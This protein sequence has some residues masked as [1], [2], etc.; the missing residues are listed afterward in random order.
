[1]RDFG[2]E[3]LH[4]FLEHAGCLANR[5]LYLKML[6]SK[7]VGW[8]SRES[9]ETYL[10]HLFGISRG[11]VTHLLFSLDST[12]GPPENAICLP[13]TIMTISKHQPSY[14]FSPRWSSS[15]VLLF[16]EFFPPPLLLL[17]VGRSV[18]KSANSNQHLSNRYHHDHLQGP[19]QAVPVP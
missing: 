10:P 6:I 2:P 13:R 8:A 11:S 7:Q 18:E 1:M 16:L 19:G 9:T 14:S 3:S 5:W 17:L 4:M 15:F 12:T